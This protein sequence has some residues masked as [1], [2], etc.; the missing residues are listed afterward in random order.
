M[1]ADSAA[2]EFA[3]GLGA[4]LASTAKR[5]DG[6]V[7]I[8]RLVLEDTGQCPGSIAGARQVS[9]VVPA[10]SAV[11]EPAGG[12]GAELAST[13]KR[14]DDVV[15]IVRLVLEDAGQCPWDVLGARTVERA[16]AAPARCALVV[17]DVAE[18][19]AEG[20][21]SEL[22]NVSYVRLVNECLSGHSTEG[23]EEELEEERRRNNNPQKRDTSSRPDT[24]HTHT[25]TA[26]GKC[27]Y[28]Q[29]SERG[30]ARVPR[31]L[32]TGRLHMPTVMVWILTELPAQRTVAQVR[33]P[34]A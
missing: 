10:D 31:A 30:H 26:V 33:H 22:S 24:R 5:E 21:C 19:L 27:K 28:N 6:V 23:G 15:V 17:G 14:E 29:E 13:A 25:S 7:V 32:G 8:F 9:G 4:E 20:V 34:P 12:L 16:A 1:P 2:L 18:V 11:V 3:D